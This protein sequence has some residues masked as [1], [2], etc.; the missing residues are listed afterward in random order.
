MKPTRFASSFFAAGLLA[1]LLAAPVAAGAQTMAER[2]RAAKKIKA[3]ST[4]KVW[5]NEDLQRLEGGWGVNVVGTS[6]RKPEEAAAPAGQAAAP[7]Q[8]APAANFYADKS[9]EEREQWIAV[10]ER[11]ISEAETELIELRSRALTAPTEAERATAA[12]QMTGVEQKLEAN[13]AELELI[14]NT[15]PPKPAKPA[16]KPKAPS[17]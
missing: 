13:R 11:E 7:A 8:P 17:F 2:S 1:A 5:T 9:M 12:Q 6:I 3:E 14:R 15:P 16:A 10:F 4:R